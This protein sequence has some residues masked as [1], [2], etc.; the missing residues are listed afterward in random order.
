[1]RHLMLGLA[2]CCASPALAEPE[3]SMMTPPKQSRIPLIEPEDMTPEQRA[4]YDAHPHARTNLGRLL[5]QAK[6]LGPAFTRFNELM[7]TTITVPPLEREIVTLAV[8]HLERGEWE[9]QQHL[10]VAEIL[11]VP[12]AKVEAIAAERFGDP[13]FTDRERALLAFTRQVVKTV[14]V[15]DPTFNAV[16]A[17]YDPRQMVE[18]I[19]VISNYMM[20]LRVS[21]VAELPLEGDA[22]AGFWKD[23]KQP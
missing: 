7:A 2:L 14:R 19:L 6:T 23:R 15:D 22:G 21:E 12:K 16:A 8:L 18:T 11:G 20:I 5:G 9:W 13:V 17:F 10:T 1:M 3:K 4:A